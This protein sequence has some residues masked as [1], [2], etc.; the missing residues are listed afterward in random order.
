MA[1]LKKKRGYAILTQKGSLPCNISRAASLNHRERSASYKRLQPKQEILELNIKNDLMMR[2]NMFILAAAMAM[3]ATVMAQEKV[4]VDTALVKKRTEYVAEKYALDGQ[5]SAK[6]LELNTKYADIVGRSFAPRGARRN[7][8]R[9]RR[10]PTEG[11][12]RLPEQ[13]N[14]VRSGRPMMPGGK[15]APAG[16]NPMRHMGEWRMKRESFCRLVFPM[17]GID[18]ALCLLY[19]AVTIRRTVSWQK[20]L[21][22]ARMDRC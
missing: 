9:A 8:D 3:C 16:R 2:R 6:L 12:V 4:A 22:L 14:S 20:A 1:L 19:T 15:R 18:R 17:R 11:G 21:C 13:G 7:F 10:N 5:Q